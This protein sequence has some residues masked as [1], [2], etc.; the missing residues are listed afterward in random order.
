[1][2]NIYWK[3][4]NPD[5]IFVIHYLSLFLYYYKFR[6]VLGHFSKFVDEQHKKR[7]IKITSAI[8]FFQTIR[9]THDIKL[10]LVFF[11]EKVVYRYV[12]HLP[13]CPQTIH[14]NAFPIYFWFFCSKRKKNCK[15]YI[16]I[17]STPFFQ[18]LHPN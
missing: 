6:V 1:M 4:A 16:S 14:I 2:F 11:I 10:N 13:F 18:K 7:K 8:Q 15:L 5:F 3:F 9:S 17:P 12:W